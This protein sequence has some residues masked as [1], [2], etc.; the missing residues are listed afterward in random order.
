MDDVAPDSRQP[1]DE[2]PTSPPGTGPDAGGG[3]GWADDADWPRRCPTCGAELQTA[4][5]DFD[6]EKAN[7]PELRPG[8]MAEVDFC[9]NPDCPT[10]EVTR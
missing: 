9:P 3:P 7:R 1:P 5:L 2:R 10:H 4:T 8:E 6:E